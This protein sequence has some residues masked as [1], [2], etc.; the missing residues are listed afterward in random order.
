M[1]LIFHILAARE[2]KEG[3]V[4]TTIEIEL[5]E[6][7]ENEEESNEKSLD[8]YIVGVGENESTKP[9]EKI[10]IKY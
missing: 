4:S 8:M 7:D 3:K 1:N 9:S 2:E 5:S 10:I 6:N